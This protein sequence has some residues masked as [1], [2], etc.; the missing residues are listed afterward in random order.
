MFRPRETYFHFFLQLDEQLSQK[1]DP[2]AYK[3]LKDTSIGFKEVIRQLAQ[4]GS[5][6]TYVG[7]TL[8]AIVAICRITSGAFLAAMVEEISLIGTCAIAGAVVMAIAVA[9]D[10]IISAITGAIERSKLEAAI[11]EM[12]EALQTFE[13]ATRKYTQTIYEILGAIKHL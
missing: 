3:T 11:A 1:L 4:W 12:D 6:F 7:A 2:Q 13:P 10:M 8:A 5:V 9:V